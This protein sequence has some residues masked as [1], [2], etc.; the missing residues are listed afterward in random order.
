MNRKNKYFAQNF[1]MMDSKKN[2][3]RYQELC[4]LEKAGVIKDLKNARDHKKEMLI[5][6]VDG[7][8]FQGTKERAITYT[9]DFMYFDCEQ[10]ITVIEEVKSEY[11][12]K[13]RDYP[14]RRK[15]LKLKIIS[16]RLN[17]HFLEI[18]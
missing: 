10:N 2:I 9:P 7:F 15:L 12:A 8:T 5:T 17:I 14:L 4:L 13:I 6:L 3:K 1:G 16:D 11:T 18:K